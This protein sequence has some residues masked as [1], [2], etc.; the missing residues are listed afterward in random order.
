MK[1]FLNYLEENQK[2]FEFRIKI[3]D[4]DPS[5]NMDRLKAALNAYALENLSAPKRLP[6]QESDIDFPAFKNCQVYLMDATL[7]YP[8]NSDQLRSIVAERAFINPA[9]IIVV[10]KNHPEEIWRWNEE[11]LSD[12]KEYKQ[13]DAELVKPLPESTAEQKAAGEAYA[14]PESILK[15]LSGV[16]L[17]EAEGGSTPAA[18]TTNE[19]PQ[20][21]ESPVGSKQNKIPVAKK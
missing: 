10:P 21:N 11:G 2:T 8:V 3:A 6:I 9:N 16:K 4:V 7:K 5:E 17:D 15:E 12:I 14:K 1:N 19:L 18:K 13:G 20:G